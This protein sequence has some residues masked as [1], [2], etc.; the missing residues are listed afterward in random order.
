MNKNLAIIL[1]SIFAIGIYFNSLSGDFVFDDIHMIVENPYIKIPEN[2]LS[3]FS[4]GQMSLNQQVKRMYRPFLMITFYLNYFFGRLNPIGYH[5]INIMFHFLNGILFIFLAKILLEKSNDFSDKKSDFVDMKKVS[6]E[7]YY[8]PILFASLLFVVHPINSE[9]VNYISARSTLLVSFFMLLSLFLYIKKDDYID[10][11][12]LYF[13]Y[14]AIL[15]FIGALLSKENALMLPFIIILY[16]ICFSNIKRLKGLSK[17]IIKNYLPLFIILWLYFNLRINLF[18]GLIK[19]NYVFTSRGYINF[20]TQIKII[21]YYL[22]LFI[23][24]SD[25]CVDRY[26][27]GS[28]SI[29]ELPVFL[30]TILVLS[31]IFIAIK[32]SKKN[33]LISFSVFWFFMN[34]VPISIVITPFNIVMSEH[35]LYLPGIGLF[36]LIGAI[37]LKLSTQSSYLH[38]RNRTIIAVI[39]I[40]ILVIFSIVTI[41]RNIIWQDS[42]TLWQD[43]IRV[44]PKSFRAHNDLGIEFIKIGQ[45]NKAIKEFR[46]AIQLRGPYEAKL[47]CNLAYAYIKKGWFNEAIK[48]SNDALII[49]PNSAEAHHN[50]GLIY[51]KKGYYDIAIE[52]YQKAIRL[53]PNIFEAH[54]N[55]GLIYYQAGQYKEAI[56]EYKKALKINPDSEVIHNNIAK[57]YNAI[58]KLAK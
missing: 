19:E 56:V 38:L 54:N 57:S 45:Y 14:G 1:I 24:P 5:I 46:Q 27:P 21:V 10:K 58:G 36:F 2:V 12:W 8:W 33:K 41:K 40:A 11:K 53:D 16:D 35:R 26:I 55:L 6:Q 7:K 29:F 18:S 9:A 23:W 42:L 30:S 3:F 39:I 51:Q 34:L 31:L 48:T 32:S 4:K 15:S 50:L 43:T 22:K 17:L 49:D 25:L 52:E 28:Q 47:Y 44:S 13:Y 20:L 37:S